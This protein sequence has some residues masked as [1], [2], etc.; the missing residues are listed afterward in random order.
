MMKSYILYGNYG[1][2]TRNGG[3]SIGSYTSNNM[4]LQ[5]DDETDVVIKNREKLANELGISLSNFVF[6]NQTHSNNYYKVTTV[7]RGKG[8]FSKQTAIQNNDAMYTF[9]KNIVLATYHADC[10]PVFFFSKKHSLI[11]VIHAGWLGTSREITYLSL[12]HIIEAYNIPPTDLTVHIGPSI[13]QECYEVKNDVAKKMLQYSEALLY[14]E[15]KIYLDTA[16]VNILQAKRLGITKIMHDN[17]CT[18]LN[19]DLFFS[20][21]R[22]KNCGRMIAFI[23]Q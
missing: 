21:R 3:Y 13:S 14:K 7:D 6:S 17:R 12:K 10:T 5:T 11:G 4:S 23:H 18:Y 9:E 15:E 2:T 1:F 20:H 22:S 8:A 19:S 16:L